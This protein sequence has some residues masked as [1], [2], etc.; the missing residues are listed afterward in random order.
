LYCN[1][2]WA[3]FDCGMRAPGPSD[4]LR[5]VQGG[6]LNRIAAEREFGNSILA[7]AEP[8]FLE[9]DVALLAEDEVVEHFDVE[10]LARFHN[11]LGHFD[12][13]GAGR[14]VSGRVIV[15]KTTLVLLYPA[16]CAIIRIAVECRK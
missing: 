1:E 3:I 8:S 14:G 7:E 2:N 6:G 15:D 9:G 13:F 10:E 5:S 4:M 12:V 16:S 11:L